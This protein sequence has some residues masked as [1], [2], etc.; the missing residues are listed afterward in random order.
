MEHELLGLI[1]TCRLTPAQVKCIM[2]QML[3]GLEYIHAKNI[4]HRDIKSKAASIL[5]RYLES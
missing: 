3:R 1:E 2:L 5:I 4:I